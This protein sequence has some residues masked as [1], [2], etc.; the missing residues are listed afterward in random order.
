[1]RYIDSVCIISNYNRENFCQKIFDIGLVGLR[2]SPSDDFC[3]DKCFMRE[4]DTY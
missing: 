1:M 2:T 4:H 3:A